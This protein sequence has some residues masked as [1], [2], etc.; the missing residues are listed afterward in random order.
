[1]IL[2]ECNFC[3]YSWSSYSVGPKLATCLRAGS[4]YNVHI[5]GQCIFDSPFISAATVCDNTEKFIRLTK[6]SGVNSESSD[7]TC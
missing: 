6:D 1:M 4:H 3:L 2:I 5:H 7:S